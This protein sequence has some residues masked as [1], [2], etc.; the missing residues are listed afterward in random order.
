MSFIRS[1]VT[2]GSGTLLSRVLGFVRDILIAAML[3]AG[4]L[5]D[6]FFVSFRLPNLFRRLFAEGAF[7]SAFVPLFAG[8]LAHDGAEEAK[9][10]AEQ[11]LSVLLAILFILTILAEIFMPG[12]MYL[13]APGFADD[14][15]QFA[16][17]VL[18]G[19]IMFP[20]LLFV[21][22]VALYGGMLNSL[23][24]FAAAALTP[25]LFNCILIVAL[26]VIIPVFG[27]PGETLSWAVAVAGVAQFLML[28]VVASRSDMRLR[29]RW[30]RLTPD[31]KRLLALTGPGAISGGIA[32][33]NLFIGTII[34]S[35]HAGAV[36][37]L[38]YADRLYQV[39]LSAI[40]T[41]I[42]VVLLP[43]LSRRLREGN[44]AGALWSLNRALEFGLLL[45]VPAALALLIIPG[46]I[47]DVMFTRG[48]FTQADANATAMAAAGFAIGLPAYV[49]IKI[50]SPAFYSREDTMTPLKFAAAGVVLNIILSVG[51]YFWI[52]FI[53]IAIATSVAAWLN[54]GL[55]W[56]SLKRQ[57]HMQ[58]D[59]QSAIR[60]PRIALSCAVFSVT[61]WAG[62]AL[63]SP[64]LV[65][66][67]GVAGM[68]ALA[69]LVLGGIGVFGVMCHF[70]GAITLGELRASLRR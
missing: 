49:L 24:Q 53:S 29:L 7:N 52:G 9:L 33:I 43:D 65:A 62:A 13:L 45:T 28:V 32:Q 17:V 35:L 11:S 50:F 68:A 19:R 58:L 2:V 10:F 39:P 66:N 67:A 40:G 48:A 69:A 16:N 56:F 21:S 44:E 34:A 15:D 27:W 51:L 23:M 61:L 64:W 63:L 4:P 31:V 41:A 59:E 70:S 12:L 8:K 60:L 25:V 22:L 18:F 26:A 30:P 3:G 36:S 57:G 20:Y 47:V 46:Q 54:A 1:A 6:A 37:Y 55:L 38:Y 5:A 42:G 14:T